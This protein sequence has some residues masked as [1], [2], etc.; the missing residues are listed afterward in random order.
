M[1][2]KRFRNRRF[3]DRT[4]FVERRKGKVWMYGE[5]VVCAVL[6]VWLIWL[7]RR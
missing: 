2:A 7:M 6:I 1:A 5:I 3:D 4:A